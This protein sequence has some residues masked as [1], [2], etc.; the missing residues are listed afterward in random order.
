MFFEQELAN[1]GLVIDFPQESFLEIARGQMKVYLPSI[2][3]I[4]VCFLKKTRKK[5]ST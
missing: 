3:N 5:R 2:F 4:N 1:Y